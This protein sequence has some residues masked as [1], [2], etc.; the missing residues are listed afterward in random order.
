L[1][2]IVRVGEKKDRDLLVW[3]LTYINSAVSGIARLVPINLARC[4][5]D[6]LHRTPVAKLDSQNI[7]L[8][9]DR[10]T[11]EWISMPP[12]GL[13][14]RKKQAPY[15]RRPSMMEC[16]LNH[17]AAPSSDSPRSNAQVHP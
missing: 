10:H 11:M 17:R 2:D 9:D 4:D 5:S 13:A 14:R 7:A 12:C 6:V 15:N 8:E 16:L 1:R 3:H